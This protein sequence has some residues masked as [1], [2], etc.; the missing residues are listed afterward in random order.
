[1]FFAH[2][3]AG[4][5]PSEWEPL[6]T[7]L[8][9]V[10]VEAERFATA[11][12][13]GPWGRLAG[14]WHDLGKYQPAF[15]AYLHPG[16][17][18]HGSEING[19]VDHSTPGAQH[20]IRE[21]TRG[22]RLLAYV[23]AGHHSG[24]LNATSEDESGGACMQNRLSKLIP[25]FTVPPHIAAFPLPAPAPPAFKWLDDATAR[26][27]QIAFFC[28]MLFSCLVDADFLA[29]EAFMNPGQS[30]LRPDQGPPLAALRDKLNA[31]LDR[32][33]ASA[34]ASPVN[35]AR[36]RVLD[37]CKAAAEFEPGFFSLTVPTG[38]GK[39]LSSLAFALH[40][41]A[42]QTVPLERVIYA[43][44]F[45]SII[46]Q[47]AGIFR[48]ALGPLGGHVLEHHGNVEP[49]R[50]TDRE[51]LAAENWDAR[52]VVTT[53]VQ[54]FESL[55]ANRTSRCRKLHRI[56]GSVIILD[57]AQSLPT[58]LIKPTLAALREL[59]ANYGCTIVLCTATQPAIQRRDDFTIGLENVREIM[60]TRAEVDQA[61]ATLRRTRVELAGRLD[62]EALAARLAAEPQVLCVVNSRAHAAELYARVALGAPDGCFHL[63]TRMCA[64]HR[65]VTLWLIRRRLR[66][67]RPCRVISTS[68]IEAGVDIDLPV[69][70][71]AMAGLD[72]I[73]Q[74]A[75]RC[76]REG[77]RDI[78]RVIVFETSQPMMSEI[79]QM[80]AYTR[81]VLPD[82]PDPLT[83]AATEHYFRLRLW[84]RKDEWDKNRIC[85]LFQLAKSGEQ[86]Q[87]ATAA[88]KYKLIDDKQVPIIVPY[89]RRGRR[90]VETLLEMTVPPKR[91]F[92]RKLQRYVVGVYPHVESELL[93]AGHILIQHERFRILVDS[94]I[95]GAFKTYDEKLGL[96]TPEKIKVDSD[97]WVA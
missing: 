54:L 96:L 29:T 83:P 64:R 42:R 35:L 28:R 86:F 65:S 76:N 88:E 27:F 80:A 78:G 44:P 33:C 7:H 21:L 68:L 43:I 74:A 50:R 53:N 51:R 93:A 22:G 15:Q 87:F 32:K 49:K 13:S 73:T 94:S 90:L 26:A 38:G 58:E 9:A 2:T 24:L 60:G 67:G 36:R 47:N 97:V 59:V 1:M 56:A 3:L 57:E 92:E 11:F 82:H 19:K 23:I 30:A 66:A 20:A 84:K 70:Y 55:F 17:D 52:V 5:P 69:V 37:H 34:D 39:T 61:F 85:D 79:A 63:S 46:E 10:A 12:A 14:L 62:D 25:A 8:F 72:A 18:V 6:E 4:R 40:H 45:T 89:G 16:A 81:E 71:R 77:R 41:A 31:M 91:S 75:G 48:R 95:K